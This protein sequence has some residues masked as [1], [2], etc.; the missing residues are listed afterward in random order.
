MNEEML[1]IYMFTGNDVKYISDEEDRED[2]LALSGVTGIR[3]CVMGFW[4]IDTRLSEAT[5]IIAR[6]FTDALLTYQEYSTQPKNELLETDNPEDYHSILGLIPY[7]TF[8][9]GTL[10]LKAINI[11]LT[12]QTNLARDLSIAMSSEAK[13]TDDESLS[14]YYHMKDILISDLKRRAGMISFSTHK[15]A[16]NNMLDKKYLDQLTEDNE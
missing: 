1:K 8:N 7:D 5:Y 14:L 15:R 3:P 9:L 16:I 10:L 13:L 12:N 4:Y 6:S 2:I 11:T